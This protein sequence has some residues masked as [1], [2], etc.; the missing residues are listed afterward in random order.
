[1]ENLR[2]RRLLPSLTVII[3]LSL[4]PIIPSEGDWKGAVIEAYERF[5]QSRAQ[6][7]EKAINVAAEGRSHT[8][9]LMC[10]TLTCISLIFCLTELA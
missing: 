9:V 10:P 4:F 6:L 3:A 8:V 2:R 7:L 1:M 5:T